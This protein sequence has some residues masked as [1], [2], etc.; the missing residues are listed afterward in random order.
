MNKS[1]AII[2]FGILA[3][4]LATS[5]II[6]RSGREPQ[7]EAVAPHGSSPSQTEASP[8]TPTEKSDTAPSAEATTPPSPPAPVAPA[9]AKPAAVPAEPVVAPYQ[10]PEAAIAALADRIAAR[11][12]DG[13][14]K[15]AGPSALAEPM[16]GELKA[17]VENPELMLD[18]NQPQAEISKSAGGRRYALNFV[19]VGKEGAKKQLYADVKEAEGK[20]QI[21]KISLPLDTPA[22]AEGKSTPP[23]GGD[24]L[25]VA[26]RFSK[27][28]M[29]RDYPTARELADSATVT[30]ERV[31]A[32]MIAIEEGKFSLRPE[33]PFVVTLD[34]EDMAWVL[35]RVQS[36]QSTSEFAI[37]LGKVGE[38]WK[39]NGLTFSKVLSALSEGAGGGRVAYSP[40]VEDPAGGDSLVLYFEF[41]EAALTSRTKRQ[42][43]IVAD[44]L[45]QGEER[46]I[47]INGHTDSLGSD[48]YNIQLSDRRA[49]SIRRELIALGVKP[50]QI[51][52]EAFG[53]SKPRKP[54][55]LPDG[56]DN[57]R[58]RS[59]NRRAEVLL[60]F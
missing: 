9:E 19:P 41:D 33:R 34:R 10:S 54:N 20:I 49:D 8:S 5:L 52:T 22:I 51:V 2:F 30:D 50:R 23:G 14:A 47:R 38:S 48:D 46:V 60:D 40:I 31:A 1:T 15:L 53:A 28:V 18:P 26:H 35:A 7:T 27:A 4:G 58:G 13:F 21:E 29:E 57:P 11:D 6:L 36:A 37:E 56:S 42:L 45:K 39:V 25:S 32:L 43:A 12:F 59:E 3:L 24:A 55:F 17:L 16:R 44:I